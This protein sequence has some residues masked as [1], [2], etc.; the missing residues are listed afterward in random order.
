MALWSYI[1]MRKVLE[2]KDFIKKPWKN[3]RG[4]THE[5]MVW[6]P[7][8]DNFDWRISHATLGESGP[9]SLFPGVSRWIV[10]LEG[11]S[12]QLRHRD[13]AHELKLLTPY[14]FQG[15]EETY[16]EVSGPG[17]DFNLMLR[18]GK[19]SGK[20]TIGTEGKIRITSRYFG[21]FSKDEMKIGGLKISK[22]SFCFFEDEKDIEILVETSGPFLIIHIE[23]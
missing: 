22:R 19:A 23:A 10:L 7:G 17:S 11:N 2:E 9:F 14:S 16:A 13:R 20:I 8:V 3:G 18:N 4:T 1:Y 5:I 12:V 6:P 21:I 15:D